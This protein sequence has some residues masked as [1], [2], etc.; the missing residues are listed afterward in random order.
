MTFDPP[1]SDSSGSFE[2]VVPAS[3]I[4][5]HIS[6]LDDEGHGRASFQEKTLIVHGALPSEFVRVFPPKKEKKRSRCLWTTVE[7][8]LE[9][10]AARVVP[11][12]CHASACGGC[13]LQHMSYDKQLEW[14]TSSIL[15]LFQPYFHSGTDVVPSLGSSEIWHYRNKMEFTFSQDL[16]GNRFLGLFSRNGRRRVENLSTCE[17]GPPWSQEVLKIVSR[18]WERTTLQAY[19][20]VQDTG[21]VRT[22]TFRYSPR[23]NNMMVILTVSGRPEWAPKKQ[24]LSSLVEALLP[25]EQMSG[26]TLSC[27]VRIHQAIKGH[28]THF[29][30]LV[31]HDGG[32][33][34]ERYTVQ[35]VVGKL[36]LSLDLQFSP[37]SFC[38]PNTAQAEKIYT[39]ALQ[40]L[41]LKPEDTLW[42][43]F[44]G[45][46]GFGLAASP[47]VKQVVGI[48]LSADS[49]YDA[50]CNKEI[51]QA[52]NL[53]IEKADVFEIVRSQE[54]LERLSLPNKCIVDP[55]RSG[56]GDKVVHLLHG[57]PLEKL[58]YVS[59]NPVSQQRDMA[60]F[61]SLGWRLMKMQPIDQFPH[62]LHM[63]NV[64]LL[65]R[66]A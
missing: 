48:E 53:V 55:P 11:Q 25:L 34:K 14:K 5:V 42:D 6:R 2:H 54:A 8:V 22:V 36:P 65:E 44:C 40:M 62:T 24:D 33:F 56:L 39:H 10:S 9:P 35:P 7:R 51:A 47:F 12:C 37:S 29:Y 45:V 58:V 30:E 15:S 46:G 18:W 27:I 61:H 17:I 16:S 1:E 23:T 38:Q 4:D 13:L 52:S 57:L 26:A 64:L 21:T 41:S 66:D 28:P 32:V 60:L 31:I 20:P 59:C 3:T 43:L 19:R 50:G 49:A 63:E